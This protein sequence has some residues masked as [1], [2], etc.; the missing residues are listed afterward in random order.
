MNLADLREQIKDQLQNL[1]N[2]IEESSTYQTLRERFEVLPQQQQKLLIGLG[3][4]LVLL[5][6]ISIPASYFSSANES[7]KEFEENREL[8]RGLL[9]AGQASQG[10]SPL[11]PSVS[12][13][14]VESQVSRA[15][16]GLALT[17]EQKGP[18][19][20]FEPSPGSPEFLASPP[21][22]QAGVSVSLKSLNLRQ[23]VDVGQSIERQNPQLRLVT[24]DVRASSEPNKAFYYDVIYRFLAFALPSAEPEE[25]PPGGARGRGGR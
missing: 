7:M 21:I 5:L 4:G 11:P 12:T 15:L 25:N 8:I 13:S 1:W 14:Q 10:A 3:A 20:A 18:I 22:Q 23:V 24:L 17:D 6:L 2:Q 9:Q 16:A 19:Q